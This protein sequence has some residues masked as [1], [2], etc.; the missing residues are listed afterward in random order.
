MLHVNYGNHGIRYVCVSENLNQGLSKCISFGRVKVDAAISAEI[1]KAIRPVAIDAAL[2]AAEQLRQRQSDRT[3]ALELEL[4]Q[5]RYEARL[6]ARRYEAIDPENRLV[7]AELESRW[8]TALSKVREFEGRLGQAQQETVST[9]SVT[10]DDLL[11]LAEDLPGVWESPSS[12]T[13]IKQRI[14]RILIQE[15]VADV[16]NSTDEVVLVIHWV[17]GRHSELRV[18]KFKTGR[19]SRCTNLDTIDVVRQMATYH[20]DAEIARTL[21]RLHLKTGAGNAWNELRV[22]S[23]RSRLKLAVPKPETSGN[24]ISML[25]AAQRLGVSTSVVRRLIDEKILPATQVLAGAP[26]AIDAQAITAP[27]VIQA[28]KKRKDR[29]SRKRRVVSEGMLSLPGMYEESAEDSNLP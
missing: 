19:H 16:D 1:L 21:N 24:R 25:Q 14:I 10:R 20:S 9:T 2:E 4:E 28:A 5:A 13:S 27:E 15:I 11:S 18:A 22:R 6:A 7:A 23:L 12:D 3:H 17:G 29:I 26:W 8:N